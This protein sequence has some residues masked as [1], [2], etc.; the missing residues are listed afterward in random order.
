[1]KDRFG[2]TNKRA[3]MCRFHVQTGGSTLTASQIDN[4]IVRTTLQAMSA[5]LGGAQSI[6]TNSK[7]EAISL[8]TDDAAKLALRTQQIIAYESGV[9]NH[10]DPFGGSETVEK[11]TEAI[12]KKTK[13]I[14]T[15]IDSLGGAISAIEQSYM[16]DQIANSAYN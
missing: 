2:V 8:P 12:I 10:P 5:V 11:M 6:H 3:L 13:S 15:E 9:I 16:Q 7:D 14:I 1:M 4:N